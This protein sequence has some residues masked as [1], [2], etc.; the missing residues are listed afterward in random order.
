MSRKSKI[1]LSYVHNEIDPI[2]DRL[3]SDLSRLD[4]VELWR[5][6]EQLK[7]GE[8]IS[9]VITK[10]IY[11]S[12]YFIQILSNKKE[13][14]WTKGSWA[15]RELDLALANEITQQNIKIITISTSHIPKVELDYYL[16]GPIIRREIINFATNYEYA[17]SALS[18][19]IK[20]NESDSIIQFPLDIFK[21]FLYAGTKRDIP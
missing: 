9:E 2:K 12:D 6:E 3:I 18:Q 21:K 1:F 13:E 11:N 15:R 16:H 20:V 7:F 19:L 5:S 10:A 8:S 17:F 4:Y 14:N